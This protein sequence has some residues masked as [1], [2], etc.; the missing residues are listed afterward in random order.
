MSTTNPT[1][2]ALRG[3][4]GAGKSTH[5]AMSRSQGCLRGGGG[6]GT[7]RL[8]SGLVRYKPRGGDWY[9]GAGVVRRHG[10]DLDLIREPGHGREA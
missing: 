3:L 5:A 8:H 1:L 6:R 9:V 4:P 10:I 7:N 2:T